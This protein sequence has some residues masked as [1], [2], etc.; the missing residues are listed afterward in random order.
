M[1]EWW[2]YRLSDFLMFSP[3]VYFRLFELQNGAWLPGPWIALA[4]GVSVLLLATRGG[5][6][7]RMAG[8]VLAAALLF[9]AWTFFARR[10]AQI[11]LGGVYLAVVFA[12]QGALLLI[13]AARGRFTVLPGAAGR[14]GLALAALAIVGWPLLVPLQGRPW[15]QSEIFGL[16]P[17]PTAAATL[18]LLLAARSIPWLLVPVPLLW[19]L[20][21]AATLASMEQPAA[22]LPGLAVVL[23]LVLGGTRYLTAHHRR[24]GRDADQHATRNP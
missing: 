2:T 11:H 13:A 16:A 7:A 4:L 24:P 18:G 22:W 19:L 20:F 10:Y 6:A 21:S 14:A 9:V 8:G 17:D 12:L 15:M 3:Q 1:S 23:A 5:T